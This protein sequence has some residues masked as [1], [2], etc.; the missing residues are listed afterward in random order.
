VRGLSAP[1]RTNNELSRKCNVPL[2]PVLINISM[3]LTLLPGGRGQDSRE[4]AEAVRPLAT[5][6]RLSHRRKKRPVFVQQE[7]P[8]RR[9]KRSKPIGIGSVASQRAIGFEN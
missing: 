2:V 4:R 5:S 8:V 9:Q 6:T 7:L 3:L 1:S